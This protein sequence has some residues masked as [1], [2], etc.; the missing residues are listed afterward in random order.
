[1]ECSSLSPSAPRGPL[2]PPGDK[3]SAAQR[4][5]LLL[6]VVLPSTSSQS[7][8]HGHNLTFVTPPNSSPSLPPL[9]TPSCPPA[10]RSAPS[11]RSSGA[12][13]TPSLHQPH[14]SGAHL[15]SHPTVRLTALSLCLRTPNCSRGFA[16][17]IRFHASC[18]RQSSQ[19]WPEKSMPLCR[20]VLLEAVPG[21]PA[22]PPA[23]LPFL[24]F[25]SSPRCSLLLPAPLKRVCLSG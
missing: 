8:S 11:L 18:P 4:R 12:Q 20:R 10:P 7:P 21:G 13:E 9:A 3:F 1:M 15:S 22:P 17:W 6:P 19:R 2:Q 14:L 16:K 24:T 5:D 25:S 23:E